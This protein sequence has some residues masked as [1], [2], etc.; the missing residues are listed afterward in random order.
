MSDSKVYDVLPHAAQRALIDEA[1]YQAMYKRSIEDPDG[2]WADMANE[3]VHWFKTWDKVADWSFDGNVN[4]RWFDGG[5]G[6]RRLELP[7]PASGGAR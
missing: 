2:F 4:I 5:Q 1:A 6:E 7:R 3:H